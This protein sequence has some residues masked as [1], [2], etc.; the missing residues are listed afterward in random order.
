MINS[1]MQSQI[2]WLHNLRFL[3]VIGLIDSTWMLSITQSKLGSNFSSMLPCVIIACSFSPPPPPI[4]SEH[5]CS[6]ASSE[7]ITC[8]MKIILDFFL[9]GEVTNSRLSL[10][11]GVGGCIH[12]LVYETHMLVKAKLWLSVLVFFPKNYSLVTSSDETYQS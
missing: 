5:V 3:V 4:L 6:S 8:D 10:S 1:H 7:S 2:Q 11:L 12:V 9:G